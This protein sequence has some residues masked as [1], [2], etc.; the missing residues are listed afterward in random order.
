MARQ[1]PS[2]TIRFLRKLEE[3]DANTDDILWIYKLGENSVKTVYREYMDGTRYT[4]SVNTMNYQQL[5][6]YLYR[7]FW[8]LGI[9]DDPFKS[10]QLFIPGYPT[11]LLR[12]DVIQKNMQG[13]FDVLM[14]SIWNW[15][16]F[17]NRN[18]LVADAG[19]S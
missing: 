6:T 14:N 10:V 1:N 3:H 9:D 8:L 16:R 17:A 7:V 15:P 19:R 11:S 2:I 4:N 18:E 5:F 12:T 13:L